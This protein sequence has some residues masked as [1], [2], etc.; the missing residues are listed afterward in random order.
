M[1]T[2]R[3]RELLAKLQLEDL[4]LILRERR[5]CW[6]GHVELLVMQSEQHVTYRLKAGGGR[7]AQANIEETD[8]EIL[9]RV[10][11]QES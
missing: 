1:A 5:L 9:P 3:S 7:E 4:D 11:A 10:E 8:R 2:V 6:F